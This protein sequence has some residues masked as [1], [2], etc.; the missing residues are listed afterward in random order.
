MRTKNFKLAANTTL[1]M[2]VAGIL[3]PSTH[4]QTENELQVQINDLQRQLDDMAQSKESDGWTLPGTNT[5]VTIG[6]YVKLDM[7]Y[8]MDQDLGDA[9]DPSVLNTASDESDSSLRVH[10]RQSRVRI[11]TSTPTDLGEAK[12]VVEADFFGSGGNELFSNSRGLRLRHAYGE[13]NGWL[14]GQTWSNF[15]HFTAYPTTV[16]FNGP[17][18]V[19]FVRQAQ[20]RYTAGVGDGQFS[21]SAENPETSG[22]EG[23]RDTVPDLTARYKWSGNGGGLEVAGLARSLKTDDSSAT[24]DDSAFGYGVMAAARLDVTDATSLM[25]GAIFGDGVG[26][27]IYSSFSNN[28]SDAGR[29]GIGE[30]YIDANGD[31]ETI[32][33]YGFNVS[34]SQQWTPKLASSL[35]YGRL[36]GDQEENLFPNSFQTLESAY[37]SNFYQ[38]ADPVTLGLELSYANKELAN[39]ES[40]DNTRLQLAAQF[41][42]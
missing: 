26:R 40:A 36:E 23:S 11:G 35:T 22:F 20:I 29:S 24:G 8:D 14:A 13:L 33:A 5:S 10:A 25:A 12:T 3:A 4:A 18:G 39:G 2:A 6:G 9:L 17:V 37:F 28:E 41:S 15:M 32:E 31:L 42:F 21:V 7:I 16:D 34:V 30:A 1:M 27:Y 38:V 19:S